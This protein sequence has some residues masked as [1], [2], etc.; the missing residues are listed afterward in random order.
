MEQILEKELK[1]LNANY[2]KKTIE[3]ML[4]FQTVAMGVS[5]PTIKMERPLEDQEVNVAY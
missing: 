1:T 4:P 2:P 5:I 3:E